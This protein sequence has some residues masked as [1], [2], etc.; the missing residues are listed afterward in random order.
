[1]ADEDGGKSCELWPG[2]DPDR[3]RPTEFPVESTAVTATG[4]AGVSAR[5]EGDGVIEVS[6]GNSG[7]MRLVLPRDAGVRAMAFSRGGDRLI[8]L[9]RLHRVFTWDLAT[10]SATLDDLGL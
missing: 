9:T 5:L 1:V 4:P 3:A 8:V 7:R 2:G 6:G 10:L